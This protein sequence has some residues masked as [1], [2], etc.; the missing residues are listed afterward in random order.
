MADYIH[1]GR[2]L[3]WVWDHPEPLQGE[4]LP[5]LQNEIMR[6]SRDGPLFTSSLS[7]GEADELSRL[8]DA[9]AAENGHTWRWEAAEESPQPEKKKGGFWR[10]QRR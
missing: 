4:T 2:K 8:C 7:P 6:L 1:L 9:V 3:M 10:R 5:L